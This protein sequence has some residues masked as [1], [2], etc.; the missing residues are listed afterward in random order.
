MLELLAA[1]GADLSGALAAAVQENQK[2]AIAT[3]LRLGATPNLAAAAGLGDVDTLVAVLKSGD[4]KEDE[5]RSALYNA[6]VHGKGAAIEALVRI[7]G[8]NID[9]RIGLETT[10]LHMAAWNG[11]A[12]LVEQ[13]L[14]LGADPSIRDGRFNA[15]PADWASHNGHAA[16][17][18]RLNQSKPT[19]P[20]P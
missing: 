9:T 10:A 1:R 17:A 6:A 2:R 12:D 4:A 14:S 16:L 19:A 8:M 11:H 5:K 15:T 3:L 18:E 7:G 20:S 13:L